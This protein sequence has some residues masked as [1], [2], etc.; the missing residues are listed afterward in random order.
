MEV[1][2]ELIT[3]PDHMNFWVIFA[4]LRG[5]RNMARKQVDL[6]YTS[7]PPH[8]EHL[9]GLLLAK[10]FRKPWVADFRD[11]MLDSSG[12][13]PA[14]RI[15]KVID[16]KLESLVVHHA[17]KI[18]IISKR[19]KDIICR[20]YPAASHKFITMPN[21]FDPDLFEK[22]PAERF[23]KF[24]I[25]YAGSFYLN[26]KPDFFLMGLNTWLKQKPV[27]HQNQVQ[28]LFYGPPSPAAQ[29]IVFQ[30]HLED[31]VSFEGMI[32]QANL[33]SK[34][35]GADLLLLIIGFDPESH[36]TVTSKV[37]EYMACQRPILAL[38][39]EGDASEIL[40]NY[41]SA[42]FVRR[43]DE[44]ILVA[45]LEKAFNRY[46]QQKEN[47]QEISPT[48]DGDKANPY[49]AQFQTKQL[50]TIFSEAVKIHAT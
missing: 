46:I 21:G 16:K 23:A 39:P 50:S 35:K 3:I 22:S 24:T 32:P 4:S 5:I 44:T 15:R 17:D 33:I 28:V 49:D 47:F 9:V 8:S 30:E 1:C 12:Y 29:Q 36:G 40:E 13:H 18:L 25:I 34:L 31:I 7:S 48:S 2:W 10:M 42:Y 27:E 38:I 45:Y 37:F 41:H 11:P 14:T 26:R 6:I 43:E 20:R 19:Y